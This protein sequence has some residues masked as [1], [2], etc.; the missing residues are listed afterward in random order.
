M[1]VSKS[2]NNESMIMPICNTIELDESGA[3]RMAE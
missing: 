3:T 1:V 2:I